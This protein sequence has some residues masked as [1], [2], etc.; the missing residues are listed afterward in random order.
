MICIPAKTIFIRFFLLSVL[1]APTLAHADDASF[2]RTL[3]AK[4]IYNTCQKILEDDS[5]KL[6]LI[7]QAGTTPENVC[8]CTGNHIGRIMIRA[9]FDL[10]RSLHKYPESIKNAIQSTLP[11]CVSATAPQH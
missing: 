9:E 10:I 4:D 5:R 3:V 7:T 8:E 6:A 1:F 11:R 2:D